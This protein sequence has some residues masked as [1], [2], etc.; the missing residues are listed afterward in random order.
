MTPPPCEPPSNEAAC[1]SPGAVP[2]DTPNALLPQGRST[3]WPHALL[4]AQCL[5]QTLVLDFEDDLVLDFAD[6][7]AALVAHYREA[8]GDPL[9][10]RP[11]TG[12]PAAILG[13]PLSVEATSQS[14]VCEGAL[15]GP[16]DTAMATQ[17]IVAFIHACGTELAKKLHGERP[18]ARLNTGEFEQHPAWQL[19]QR[20]E[21]NTRLDGVSRDLV[22]TAHKDIDMV[23]LQKTWVTRLLLNKR[24]A[25]VTAEIDYQTRTGRNLYDG[26]VDEPAL[27]QAL[28]GEKLDNACS[29]MRRV[30]WSMEN[31]KQ[32][33][34]GTHN[35][36]R[37]C[38][39]L[40][41]K[42][43]REG[44]FGVALA[45]LAD[46]AALA[47]VLRETLAVHSS[48]LGMLVARDL[49][50]LLPSLVSQTA[51]DACTVVGEGAEAV[52]AEC[53]AGRTDGTT[54]EK[55]KWHY[56]TTCKKTFAGRLKTLHENLTSFLDPILLELVVPQ[57]WTLDL[58]ENACCE[59]RRWDKA[60]T[61]R[62]RCLAE[63]Q[64]RQRQR[65]RE[66]RATWRQLGFAAAPA[67]AATR[68]GSRPWY[69]GV[70]LKP[71]LV[72]K[73]RRVST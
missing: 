9:E 14:S 60:Q 55:G 3:R 68:G 53:T 2:R 51:V 30:Q 41:V 67:L 40:W 70:V 52:L 58:T 5:R 37:L 63:S 24:G 49:A 4:P 35:Q 31:K 62:K 39:A 27:T 22:Y 61:H 56:S 12:T 7:E 36:K 8:H 32:G 72:S 15:S 26:E 17:R 50:V 66:V 65:L 54:D 1:G 44:A 25:R 59:L 29:G 10:R 13:A 16:R 48:F 73:R 6:E 57:G 34:A 46:G 21:V 45:R 71:P 19:H 64:E 47:T 28:D 23:K 43:R 69:D 11:K 33:R 20:L 42:L 38:A 18:L